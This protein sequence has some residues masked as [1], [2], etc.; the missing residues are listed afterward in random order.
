MPQ[1]WMQPRSDHKSRFPANLHSMSVRKKCHVSYCISNNN[2]KT[3]SVT[4]HSATLGTIEP[5]M[6]L[7]YKRFNVQTILM[8][9]QTLSK[10]LWSFF[11]RSLPP[12]KMKVHGWPLEADLSALWATDPV[13]QSGF[14]ATHCTFLWLENAGFHHSS[15]TAECFA[16]FRCWLLQ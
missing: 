15:K 11:Y 7:S 5:G 10:R 3:T 2:N 6:W 13:R 8:V 4:E 12:H 1:R 14:L 9:K 16:F